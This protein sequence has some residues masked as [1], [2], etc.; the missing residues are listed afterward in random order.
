MDRVRVIERLEKIGDAIEH[1]YGNGDPHY[2]V[3]V[4]DTT[5]PEGERNLDL[6]TNLATESIIDMLVEAA[7]NLK[8]DLY[9]A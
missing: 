1:L 8:K 2:I 6:M 9:D 3:L 7:D 5:K 4:I